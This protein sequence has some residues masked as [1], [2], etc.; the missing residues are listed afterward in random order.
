[1][2]LSAT[3]LIRLCSLNLQPIGYLVFQLMAKEA[4]FDTV[5]V[6][7]RVM[8]L[9]NNTSLQQSPIMSDPEL[10]NTLFNVCYSI[11]LSN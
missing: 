1:L 4:H 9:P 11:Y 3:I 5:I 7:L 10:V 8:N 6:I 2:L